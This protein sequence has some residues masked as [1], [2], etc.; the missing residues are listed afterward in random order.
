M[1]AI[2]AL[3]TNGAFIDHKDGSKTYILLQHHLVRSKRSYRSSSQQCTFLCRLKEW[4]KPFSRHCHD[5]YQ[6]AWWL[7]M[8][9]AFCRCIWL[10]E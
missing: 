8:N 7:L 5:L 4:K 2:S 9:D 3:D 1:I 10:T 6:L